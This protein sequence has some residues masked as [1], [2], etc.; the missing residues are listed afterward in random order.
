MAS[1]RRLALSQQTVWCKLSS[2]DSNPFHV[3]NGTL[4][5]GAFAF[6]LNTCALD[7]FFR[8][9]TFDLQTAFMSSFLNTRL[10]VFKSLYN[11]LSP[12][13]RSW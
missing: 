7:H 1:I 6:H 4:Q 13:W 12:H 9:L 11:F 10:K 2:S 8:L 5:C 3:Y